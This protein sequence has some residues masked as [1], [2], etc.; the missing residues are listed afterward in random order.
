MGRREGCG[1][2]RPA[3]G[4]QNSR[5][6]RRTGDLSTGH[7]PGAGAS[8]VALLAPREL[9]QKLQIRV[10]VNRKPHITRPVILLV[11]CF[12]GAISATW[13]AHETYADVVATALLVS[14]A[15]GMP[16]LRLRTRRFSPAASEESTRETNALRQYV[17]DPIA[18]CIE[19]DRPLDCGEREVS[20]MFVDLC[21][22]TAL[23]EDL[24][25]EEIF[26]LIDRYSETVSRVIHEHGGFVVEFNGDGLMAVFGAPKRLAEK[27][28]AAVQA[29]QGVQEAVSSLEIGPSRH[30]SRKLAVGIGITTG[31]AFVGKIHAADRCVWGAIGTTT[32]LASRIEALSRNLDASIVVDQATRAA[33]GL[34][35]GWVPF[36]RVP[37]RGLRAPV[38]LYA[39][40]REGSQAP[41]VS[42]PAARPRRLAWADP[43]A[44]QLE[45]PNWTNSAHGASAAQM[46]SSSGGVRG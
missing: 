35:P 14:F 21:G 36:S 44:P 1:G 30:R 43:M 29:A 11:A 27:E 5:Q 15:V 2:R 42:S 38:D 9:A 19:H 18:D 41:A 26:S 33:A 22:Y 12:V 13:N 7:P 17:P 28:R 25:P 31:R 39:L 4:V 3:R 6:H 16:T 23:C 37:I 10:A 20:V 24:R 40:I 46:A 45:C 34:G 8:R 32:N